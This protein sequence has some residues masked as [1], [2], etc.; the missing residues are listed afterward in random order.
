VGYVV[1]LMVV[2]GVLWFWSSRKYDKQTLLDFDS[3]LYQYDNAQS[4]LARTR[5]AVAFLAQSLHFAWETGAINSKQKDQM[6]ALLKKQG[7][8]TSVTAFMGSALPVVIRVAGDE[9]DVANA[10]ARFVG[11]L[12]LLA[13]FAQDGCAENSIRR[14]IYRR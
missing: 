6:S 3:W 12:M 10:Q 8:T 5:M 7:A 9:R 2:L 13:W 14:F 1:G 11:M 4:P